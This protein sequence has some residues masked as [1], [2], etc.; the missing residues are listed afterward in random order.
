MPNGCCVAGC[1]SGYKGNDEKVSLFSLPC[2]RERREKWNYAIGRKENPWVSYESRHLRVCEKHFDPEDIIRH[3][4]CVMDGD[5][6]TLRRTKPQLKP[7]A[8]PRTTEVFPRS[9]SRPKARSWTRGKRRRVASDVCG[10]DLTPNVDYPT[11]VVKSGAEQNA[12]VTVD[13]A[14]Q[15]VKTPDNSEEKELKSQLRSTKRQLRRCQKKLAEVTAREKEL[16]CFVDT[17][18]KLTDNE[19]LI[20]DQC[21]MKAHAESAKAAQ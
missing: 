4:V 11:I 16:S 3:D 6:V 19:K 12:R 20:L 21:L 1:R 10:D 7:D 18:Q 2:N 14:C 9:S 17:F 5:S 15:T 13:K 8:V